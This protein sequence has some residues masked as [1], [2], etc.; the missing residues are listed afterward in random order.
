MWCQPLH[1]EQRVRR[2]PQP[3]NQLQARMQ[4][5]EEAR[6]ANIR[7]ADAE[8][9]NSLSQRTQDDPTGDLADDETGLYGEA[10]FLVSVVMYSTMS[11]NPC[12]S[13]A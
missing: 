8:L 3:A 13:K 11:T 4:A 5:E 12:W 7:A 6:R 1:V 2:I 10:Y 9:G